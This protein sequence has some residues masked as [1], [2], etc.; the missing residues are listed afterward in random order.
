MVPKRPIRGKV[1]REASVH[2]DGYEVHQRS[3]GD[4]DETRIINRSNRRGDQT[5][6]RTNR[7][8]LARLHNLHER[9]SFRLPQGR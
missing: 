1:D 9:Q 7:Q 2:H 6:T 3:D 4:E 5:P 8:T